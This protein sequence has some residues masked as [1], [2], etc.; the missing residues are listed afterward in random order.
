LTALQER[1]AFSAPDH[2]DWQQMFR[3]SQHNSL[4]RFWELMNIAIAAFVFCYIG[5]DVLDLDLSNFSTKQSGS[6]KAAVLDEIAKRS[7]TALAEQDNFPDDPFYDDSGTS[8]SSGRLTDR[9]IVRAPGLLRIHHIRRTSL[10]RSLPSDLA[11]P[12]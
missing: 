11:S 9:L 1:T 4:G 3:R 6:D 12:P 7:V 8:K 2:A 5:F 10:P